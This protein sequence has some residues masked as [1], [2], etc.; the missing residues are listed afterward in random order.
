MHRLVSASIRETFFPVPKEKLYSYLG[1]FLIHIQTPF[2][3]NVPI[4]AYL[5]AWH[6]FTDTSELAIQVI[7][8]AEQNSDLSAKL[9]ENKRVATS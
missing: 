1:D 6:G 9:A 3:Y 5:A 7:D 2:E 8:K 4:E